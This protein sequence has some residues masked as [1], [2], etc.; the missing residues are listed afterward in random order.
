MRTN[1]TLILIEVTPSRPDERFK[2][3]ATAPRNDRHVCVEYADTMAI[4]QS[5]CTSAVLAG[6][7]LAKSHHGQRS[8]RL[9]VAI[10]PNSTAE[11][12][13]HK[14]APL[15]AAPRKREP[16]F[17]RRRRFNENGFCRGVA[18]RMGNCGS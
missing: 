4:A 10:P 16:P 1:V 12:R 6:V 13:L 8:N 14:L 11:V 18:T 9:T 7:A 2:L 5:R 3:L 17:L 15:P